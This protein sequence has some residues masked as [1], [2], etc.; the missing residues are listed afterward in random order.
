MTHYPQEELTSLWGRMT[1][2]LALVESA[3]T[4]TIEPIGRMITDTAEKQAFALHVTDA[5]AADDTSETPTG[6]SA[7]YTR[8]KLDGEAWGPWVRELY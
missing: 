4:D 8:Q 7:T 3:Q 2:Y 6:H 1:P 5:K